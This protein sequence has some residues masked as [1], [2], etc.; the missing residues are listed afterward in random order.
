MIGYQDVINL[1]EQEIKQKEILDI[2]GAQVLASLIYKYKIDSMKKDK[3]IKKKRKAV[4][5]Y[6]NKIK[7]GEVI[8][9]KNLATEFNASMVLCVLIII[10]LKSFEEEG[11]GKYKKK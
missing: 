9:I 11:K 2:I 8:N 7:K 4:K 6:L 3:E 10:K 5:Q 1:A